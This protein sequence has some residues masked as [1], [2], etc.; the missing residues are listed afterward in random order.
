MQDVVCP[1]EVVDGLE[2]VR[3]HFPHQHV[4]IMRTKSDALE[5]FTPVTGNFQQVVDAG[6]GK[7]ISVV[8]GS[9]ALG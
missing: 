3:N 6:F 4:E 8:V 5:V 2:D 9:L 1:S 7:G